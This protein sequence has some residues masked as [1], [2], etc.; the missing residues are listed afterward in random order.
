MYRAARLEDDDKLTTT[1][2]LPPSCWWMGNDAPGPVSPWRAPPS[3]RGEADRVA[4]IALVHR[5][6]RLIRY[7]SP[8]DYVIRGITEDGV[9]AGC[10]VLKDDYLFTRCWRPS[11]SGALGDR[12]ETISPINDVGLAFGAGRHLCV[13]SRI[14]RTIV[15]SAFSALSEL[16]PM[17]LAGEVRHGR[18][19]LVR[20]LD[21]LPVAFV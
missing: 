17:R 20:T 8:V 2:I 19:K 3:R 16:P 9:I 1:A 5:F 7:S 13:G 12:G 4:S 15:K 11:R 6:R 21:S 14:T 10:P 18:G